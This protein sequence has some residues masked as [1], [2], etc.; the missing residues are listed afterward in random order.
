MEGSSRTPFCNPDS[1]QSRL[2]PEQVGGET[3]EAKVFEVTDK[4]ARGRGEGERVAPEDPL[5]RD[6]GEA[7]KGQVDHGQGVFAPEQAGVEEP[8]AGGHD[9]DCSTHEHRQRG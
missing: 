7:G 1:S 6:D 9:H 5:D 4:A 8:D 2:L 3:H